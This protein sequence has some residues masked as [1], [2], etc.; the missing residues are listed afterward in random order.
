M[1]NS[2]PHRPRRK[3]NSYGNPIATTASGEVST[4]SPIIATTIAVSSS[5]TTIAVSSSSTMFTVSTIGDSSS[6]KKLRLSVSNSL[7]TPSGSNADDVNGGSPSSLV[8]YS[9]QTPTS[10]P[11]S[12]QQRV[13]D[14]V[15]CKYPLS[16]GWY[17]KGTKYCQFATSRKDKMQLHVGFSHWLCDG[18]NFLRLKL[19]DQYPLPCEL[20]PTEYPTIFSNPIERF[21]H[22]V[23]E[24]KAFY[25]SLCPDGCLR[26]FKGLNRAAYHNHRRTYHGADPITKEKKAFWGRTF[27]LPYLDLL[28]KV[29]SCV[30]QGT[31]LDPVTYVQTIPR[32]G[33]DFVCTL[34]GVDPPVEHVGEPSLEPSASA[35]LP[36]IRDQDAMRKRGGGGGKV[37]E[38]KRQKRSESRQ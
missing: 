21:E 24:H 28:S 32:Q 16:G 17:R 34:L 29:E 9:P 22:A 38:S 13:L 8:P 2:A 14:V 5:S 10:P 35:A 7:P 11:G 27:Y 37:G 4:T 3:C 19:F 31:R 12:P 25:L 33:V 18:D 6:R 1:T 30:Q 20:C 36:L 23:T 26:I 15:V